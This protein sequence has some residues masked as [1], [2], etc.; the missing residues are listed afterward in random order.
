MVKKNPNEV[1]ICLNC[2]KI[3]FSEKRKSTPKSIESVFGCDNLLEIMQK[4]IKTIDSKKAFKN[5]Q[6]DRILYLKETLKIP[7]KNTNVYAGV[8]MKG[9][10]GTETVIDELIG[11]TVKTVGKTSK[12]QFHSLP[13]FF[14]IYLNPK[15]MDELLFMAQS[16]KQYG[17]KE[18]F[19]EAF[20]NF[21]YII[22]NN[23]KTDFNPLSVA[24]L[25]ERYVKE[26]AIK[27]MRFIKHGLQKGVENIIR[28]DREPKNK[29]EMEMSI[30]ASKGFF[31][32][33]KVL[34]Y[35]DASF[36]EQVKIDGFE[37]DE[38]FADV[39]IAGRKRVLNVSKPTSFST[40]Y[41][42][43]NKIEIDKN[44]NLPNFKNVMTE[45]LDILENDLIPY[46]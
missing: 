16:Y 26:G 2:Y 46:V 44:T 23:T 7:S 27:K 25:F 12:D 18:V 1:A 31:G 33:K 11:S 3:R 21:T 10:N 20:T 4:F 24:Q 32:I 38:A 14:L 28:E 30:K 41:D 37:F 13:Y 6:E 36:I 43:T 8:V 5:K 39:F 35:D 19:D 17:F 29:Y 42:I 45:A 34:K 22:S 40:A 9:H 15:K